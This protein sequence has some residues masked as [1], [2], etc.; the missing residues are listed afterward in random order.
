MTGA[1]L[2]WLNKANNI[3]H[4]MGVE[5]QQWS[6]EEINRQCALWSSVEKQNKREEL[7]ARKA[8][9]IYLKK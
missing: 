3:M 8:Y 4:T 9:C 5:K 7:R 1:G 6:V 2:T